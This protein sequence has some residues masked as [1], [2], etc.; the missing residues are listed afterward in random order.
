MTQK[1]EILFLAHRIPYPPDKGDKIRS[2]RLLQYLTE[3]F[4][5]HLVSFIDDQRDERHADF[6]REQCASATFIAIEPALRKVVCVLGLVTGKALSVQFY[7]NSKMKTVIDEIRR[8]PLAYEIAFSSTMAQYL[9]QPGNAS[10]RIID[11][12][13][14]DSEKWRRYADAAPWPMSW[15]Y[16][17]EATK[18]AVE[19]SNIISWADHCFAI[20]EQEANIFNSRAGVSKPVGWWSNGVD[21]EYFDPEAEF[22]CHEYSSDVIFTGAMDYRANVEAVLGFVKNTWP[23]IRE[24]RPQA[25]F[26]IVGARPVRELLALHQRDGI[27]VTGRVDDIRPWL[28]LAKVAI[29]PMRVAQGIQNKVLEAMAM[30]KPVVA[31]TAAA[32]GLRV[33]DGESILIRDGVENVAG[34]IL[35][36]LNDKVMRQEIGD[37]ARR[38]VIEIY[39]WDRQLQ[40]FSIAI[41]NNEFRYSSAN[42]SED[43][44]SPPRSSAS[45]N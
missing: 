29:A 4:D 16:R 38:C 22:S 43:L 17:R 33:C 34:E 15:V 19:E 20:T 11:F 32:T 21:A 42:E 30:G 37:N 44:A 14:A 23:A 13:D 1:P 25:T 41:E 45:L 9:E 27:I 8:K 24:K 2:W 18:M 40:R 5:V 36:L 28:A 10:A 39:N 12:C 31:S 3:R 26:T 6:L 35:Q 7:R